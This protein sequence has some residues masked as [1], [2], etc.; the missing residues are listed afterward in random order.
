M[1]KNQLTNKNNNN[2]NV[3]NNNNNK[4]NENENNNT[5]HFLNL[6]T[7]ENEMLVMKNKE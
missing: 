2:T 4:M 7:G 6:L 1:S 5:Q 3:M